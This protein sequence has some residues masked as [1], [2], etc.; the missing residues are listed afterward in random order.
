MT[1]RS[2]SPSLGTQ[3][4]LLLVE[5]SAEPASWIATEP[6]AGDEVDD[7]R[8]PAAASLGRRE[9]AIVAEAG[10]LRMGTAAGRWMLVA[11]ISGRPLPLDPVVVN[12]ALP[13]IA[14]ELGTDFAGLQWIVTGY[15]LTLASLILLG[16]SLGELGS[17][18]GLL[19]WASSG[20]QWP[21]CCRGGPEY[22]T[23]VAARV[24][25]G[26]GGALL[27][28]GSLAMISAFPR[29]GP[30][31]AIGAWSGFGGVAAAWGRSSAGGSS[32][33]PGTRSS[34]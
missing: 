13:R 17:A 8:Q 7:H 25:Q 11:T 32:S 34:S 22:E 9:E 3:S 18:Q 24:L 21:R 6:T 30:G 10:E 15:T 4:I 26:V 1:A 27:T 28:P 31:R 12:I 5:G 19:S 2:S 16:G 33:R 14:G 29:A 20:S 23:I